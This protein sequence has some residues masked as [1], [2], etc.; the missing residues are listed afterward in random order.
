VKQK[1]KARVIPT[2]LFQDDFI[3]LIFVGFVQV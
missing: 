3:L 1:S 2:L